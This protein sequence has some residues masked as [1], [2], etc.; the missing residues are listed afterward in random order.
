MNHL[1][2]RQVTKKYGSFKALDSVDIQMENGVYGLLGHN[3]AGKTTLMKIL[4]KNLDYEGQVL[5]QGQEI[6]SLG[7]EYYDNLGY[8][9]QQL[10]LNFPMT[11]ESFLYYMAGLK[12]IKNPRERIEELLEIL[13]LQEHKKKMLGGLS[14]GMKQRVLIAQALLNDPKI[15]LLDEPTAGLDPI[16][17]QIFRELIAD[18]SGER[19]ILL[20]THVISDVEYIA[21]KILI[22]KKG[23]L[24]AEKTQEELLEDCKVFETFEELEALKREDESIREINRMRLGSRV[25]YRFLSEKDYPNSV[26]PTL[27]DVYI[28]WLG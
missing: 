13:D 14:G 10:N 27:D 11:A 5:W 20:S 26:T 6:R 12:D 1:E 18:L 25:K 7:R 4:A 15:L 22:L 19:V 28:Q 2:I 3:G 24:L 8:M 17:R 16:Q 23:V 9:P 21:E